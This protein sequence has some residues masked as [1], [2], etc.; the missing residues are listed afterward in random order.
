MCIGDTAFGQ[1]S[2]NRPP[3]GR[4]VPN[5]LWGLGFC[6]CVQRI[7]GSLTPDRRRSALFLG[8]VPLVPL[9]RDPSQI[10]TGPQGASAPIGGER[11]EPHIINSV[12]ALGSARWALSVGLASSGPAHSPAPVPFRAQ[13]GPSPVHCRPLNRHKAGIGARCWRSRTLHLIP[14]RTSLLRQRNQRFSA[15]LRGKIVIR[16]SRSGQAGQARLLRSAA[17]LR[18]T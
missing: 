2:K 11:S 18:V 15:I 17:P 9:E 14:W 4:S 7:G 10:P 12:N 5:P 1:M 3:F 8:V 16:A 6:R 13:L